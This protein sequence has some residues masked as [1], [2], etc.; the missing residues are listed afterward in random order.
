MQTS[1]ETDTHAPVGFKPAIPANEQ[2]QSH[3]LDHTANSIVFDV[4][5]FSKNNAS[6][7][8]GINCNINFY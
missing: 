6:P 4:L 2:L 7:K 1:Q 8:N 3:A 5:T